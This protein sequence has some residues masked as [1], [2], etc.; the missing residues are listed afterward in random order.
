MPQIFLTFDDGPHPIYTPTILEILNK[1][2]VKAT[3]FVCGKNIE[4]YPKILEQIVKN[5]HSVGNHSYSHSRLLTF[6]GAFR[7]EIE[8]TTELILKITSLKTNL[9]RPP[10][11]IRPPWLTRYLKRNGYQLVLW[12]IDPEDW[13]RIPAE[14]IASRVIEKAKDNC[15]VLLHD[16]DGIRQ[17]SSRENTVKAIPII[18]EALVEKGYTFQRIP[19]SSKGIL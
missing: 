10:W 6:I 17:K 15:I 2:A 19:F 16:G 9:F 5:K 11:G 4:K 18:I 1:Y 3:F 8:R 12:D 13:Q 14:K 7:R